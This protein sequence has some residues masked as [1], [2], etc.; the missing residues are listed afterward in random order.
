MTNFIVKRTTAADP[1]PTAGVET[2]D[3]T[4]SRR[5]VVVVANDYPAG[6]R[7]AWHR[8][9]RAQLVYAER[10]VMAVTTAAGVWVIPPE[11][12]VWVPAHTPHAVEMRTE[13]GMRSIFVRPKWATGLPVRPGVVA[14]SPLLRELIRVAAELPED[15]PDDGPEARLTAVLLDRLATLPAQPLHLPMPQAAR[16]RPIVLGLLDDPGD[17]RTLDAWA[18]EAGASGR[19][20]ARLFRDECGMTFGAWR[21]Q[22]RLLRALEWL[23]LGRPVTQVA[24]DLGYDSPSAFT[25]MF[26]RALGTTPGHYYRTVGP[27]TG[28]EQVHGVA[29]QLDAG[30]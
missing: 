15:Y 17:R 25:A 11:R 19:T 20:L 29:E 2:L 12:A 18:R 5:P 8:H 24:L 7:T 1:A 21:Q 27:E 3:L 6:H 26:R 14:V 28:S 23:A 4:A 10:G 30:H 22:L 16:L 9:R 13:V